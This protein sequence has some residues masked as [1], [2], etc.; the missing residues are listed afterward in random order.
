ML[1]FKYLK[2]ILK[3]PLFFAAI[4]LII[5]FK[6]LR[7][8]SQN[9]NSITF[10][11]SDL[12]N[13]DNPRQRIDRDLRIQKTGF[14]IKLVY[15]ENSQALSLDFGSSSMP[16]TDF[17]ELLKSAFLNNPAKLIPLF[18]HYSGPSG[19][20]HN[21]F[22]EAG[23]SKYVYFLPVGEKWPS[24]DYI[25][26]QNKS[27]IIFTFQKTREGNSFFHYAWD[28][29]AEFPSS[30]IEDPLFDGFLP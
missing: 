8:Y 14:S 26:E 24:I 21:S 1:I 16:F 15:E 7:T 22:S 10:I 25:K 23:L 20:L 13:T 30:G 18:I 4:A 27:I 2:D 11:V 5:S 9:I 28:Y 29:I 17:A 19:I 3:I 6:P 12:T